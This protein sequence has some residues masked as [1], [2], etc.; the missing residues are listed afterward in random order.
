MGPVAAAFTIPQEAIDYILC[1]GSGVSQ[2]KYRILEQ[3]Q[4]NEGT[5]GQH[6]VPRPIPGP[7][8]IGQDHLN[9]GVIE[10]GLD[11]WVGL[12]NNIR[13]AAEEVALAELIYTD[14]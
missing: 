2:G 1:G 9:V 13:A 6:I 3:F 8:S 11:K 10:K 7:L 14:V 5:E 12:M 4:K